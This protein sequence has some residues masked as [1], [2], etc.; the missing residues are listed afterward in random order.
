MNDSSL[1]KRRFHII[2]IFAV[3]AVLYFS[4]LSF[5]SELPLSTLGLP[6]IQSKCQIPALERPADYFTNNQ[7]IEKIMKSADFR[8]ASIERLA[9]AVRVNTAVH[10]NAPLVENDGQYWESR[11]QPFHD[12]LEKTFPVAWKFLT[13]EKVNKWAL[14]LTWRGTEE[15]LKPLVLTAHQDVVPANAGDWKY[16]PFEGRHDEDYL[17]GRGSS[18]CKNLLIGLLEAAEELQGN[19]FKPQRTIVFAFGFDEEIGGR[20]GAA[21]LNRALYDRYGENGVYAIIDEGGQSLVKLGDA[22][23]ALVGTGEKGMFN[24]NVNLKTP[25]GHSSVPPDHTS[26]G[27]MSELVS[28]VEKDPFK[29]IFSPRNPTFQQYRCLAEHSNY[30]NEETRNAVLASDTDTKAAEKVASFIYNSSRGSRY[31]ITTSQAVD[32]INGGIKSNALPENVDLVMNH[33]VAV[34]NSTT[35]ILQRDL[36]KIQK[37]AGEFDVGVSFNGSILRKETENGLFT[38]ST[39]WAVEPAPL[40]PTDD[41][42]WLLFTGTIRHVYE[43]CAIGTMRE[44]E[45]MTVIPTPG[46]APGSTDTQ[47]YWSLTNHIYRYRPGLIPSVDAHAHGVDEKVLIDSHLQLIAFYHELLLVLDKEDA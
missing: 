20:N 4:D 2:T 45:G 39:S 36:N 43:E 31:L 9:G 14:L 30:M 42:L 47:H 6:R 13:V 37:I 26:I 8:K 34:E 10:D 19:G 3:L 28:S 32:I 23:V 33:R 5:H 12:Y 21:H 41:K 17:W 25:G 1:S 29:P 24:I 35:Q 46:M 22:A 40:T 11:F 7:T 16:P 15:K 38:V 44:F 27:I 18:D